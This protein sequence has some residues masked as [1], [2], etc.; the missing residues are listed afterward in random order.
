M[1]TKNYLEAMR[2]K[3]A[4]AVEKGGKGSA[5]N[6]LEFVPP[7]GKTKVR[8]LPPIAEDDYFYQTHSY[9]FIPKGAADGKDVMLWT[10]KKYGAERCPVDEAAA[11]FYDSNDEAMRKLGSQIKRKRRFYFNAILVDEEDPAKKFVVLVDNTNEGKLTAEI[12]RAMNIPLIRDV[13]DNWIDAKVVTV[14][15]DEE[16]VDLL[17]PTNG[18]DFIINK[19]EEATPIGGGRTIKKASYTGSKPAKNP[20]ALTEEEQEIMENKRV[21][22]KTFVSYEKDVN[23]VKAALERF[24]N[25]GEET[26]EV[27]E[28]VKTP[29][30]TNPPAKTPSAKVGVTANPI[31]KPQQTVLDAEAE[32]LLNEI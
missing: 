32:E 23:K 11:Q 15:P 1:K 5:G 3:A 20:R 17:D 26:E 21:D 19:T 12:C 24:I 28:E 9:N 27:E 8:L 14:D 10:Q 7:V 30:T 6:S 25:G 18:F 29:K 31:K 4:A 13:E 2:A 22:L 16:G